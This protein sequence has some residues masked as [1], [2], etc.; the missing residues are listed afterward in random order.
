VPWHRICNSTCRVE[1]K[2]MNSQKVNENTVL[3]DLVSN[4][5][6][7]WVFVKLCAV[8]KYVGIFM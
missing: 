5:K 3:L 6:V 8:Y 7:N 1:E 4:N 2:Y